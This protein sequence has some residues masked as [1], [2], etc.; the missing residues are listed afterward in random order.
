M[1]E[2]IKNC[3]NCYHSCCIGSGK[4][5]KALCNE[6]K[7]NPMEIGFKKLDYIG[8]N[9]CGKWKSNNKDFF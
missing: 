1:E 4:T 6:D 8:N 5:A 3:G 2:R 7:N 9:D